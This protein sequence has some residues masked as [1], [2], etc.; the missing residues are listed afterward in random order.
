MTFLKTK[1]V[2][3]NNITYAYDYI[4]S[5]NV[6]SFSFENE[7]VQL[8]R[9][10]LTNFVDYY[11]TGDMRLG[12]CEEDI[13]NLQE[14]LHAFLQHFNKRGLKYLA[15]L[16]LSKKKPCVRLLVNKYPKLNEQQVNDVW[17]NKV[18]MNHQPYDE[19]LTQYT[20][21][22]RSTAAVSTECVFTSDKL[23]KPRVLHNNSAD[24]FISERELLDCDEYSTYT[25]F[26]QEYGNITVNEYIN[27]L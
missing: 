14:R 25:I 3:C 11:V 7:E 22:L 9:L 5:K 2:H 23:K 24:N 8:E 27:I 12:I 20:K 26:D 4:S 10:I 6:S 21:A 19:L 17:G 18:T 1:L 16:D 13:P 15:V